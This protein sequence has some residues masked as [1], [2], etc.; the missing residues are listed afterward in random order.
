MGLKEDKEQIKAINAEIEELSKRLRQAPSLF[1]ASDIE[2]AKTYLNGLKQDLREVDSE[3]SYI[4]DSFKRSL[5]ELSKQN[6]ALN[7]GKNSLRAISNISSQLLSI[8][9]G[10]VDADSRSLEKL[11]QKAQLKFQELQQSI[12]LLETENAKT[13]EFS[14][15]LA[16]L[17]GAVAAQSEFLRGQKQVL[18]LQKK[19]EGDRGVKFFD[20]LGD[21]AKAIPGLNK[22]TGA[23]QEAAKAAKDTAR[24]NE[25]TKEYLDDLAEAEGFEGSR[26]E[27]QKE[28][29]KR[30][31]AAKKQREADLEALKTGKGLTEEVQKRLF[32][33]E[34]IAEAKSENE[35]AKIQ[36]E[37]DLSS[38]KSG[39]GLTKETLKR[40]GIEKKFH[41]KD[42]LN[43]LKTGKGLTKEKIKQLG[44]EDKLVSKTGKSL[45]GTSAATKARAGLLA[46]VKPIKNIVPK[47]AVKSLT[48]AAPKAI[49]SAFKMGAKVL[50]KTIS[51]L[52]GPIGL[53]IE[54]VIALF[55]GDK[56][57][58]EL[59][60]SMNMTY[61]DA[62]ATRREFTMIAEESGEIFV[63]TKGIQES[64][65]ALNKSL[66]TNVMLNKDNLVFATMMREQMGFSQE[67]I[68]TTFKLSKA[69]GKSMEQITGE[70][71]AQADITATNLGVQLEEKEILE[72]V[73]KASAATTLSLKGSGRELAKAVTTAKALGMTLQQI[74]NISDN[75][76]NFEQ[77][78][79]NE[80][81]A[82]LLI[83][84]N[85]N[86]ERARL[87]AINN[88]IEGVAREIASQFGSAAE[89]GD[90]NRMQQKAIAEAVGM[91]RDELAE[92]L[93]TQQAIGNATGKEAD[94]RRAVIA[95]M[96]KTMSIEEAQRKLE[97]EG[98][99][100]LKKQASTQERFNAMLDKLTEIAVQIGEP[101]LEIIAPIA[102]L[103]EILLPKIT[104]GL[105]FVVGIIRGLILVIKGIGQGI[106]ALF[107]ND[108]AA[109]SYGDTFSE[110]GS[111]FTRGASRTFDVSLYGKDGFLA[112]AGISVNEAMG[113]DRD[114]SLFTGDNSMFDQLM[115]NTNNNQNSALELDRLRQ[116]NE[117]NYQQQQ[118]DMRELISAVRENRP[119]DDI[120]G[121]IYE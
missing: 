59:A 100:N 86:L 94:E 78:I 13:G 15:Q 60:K 47:G 80:L 71:I 115:G 34:Q 45:A 96:L 99:E 97:K 65:I 7:Q 108:A 51:K 104:G 24:Q 44:L 98:I 110:A 37:A 26:K 28:L 1:K 57:A 42:N 27:F 12:R 76:L 81:K 116:L 22:F 68:N 101:L 54:L 74:E 38:L 58:G 75:I 40:L 83:G 43:A 120:F 21:I 23:F 61:M 95:G 41:T 5:Q 62:L 111:A 107:G 87:F 46:G 66:G 88:N 67:A 14:E 91:T 29:E 103:A 50:T 63:T 8:K 11:Q 79:T 16:E 32:T 4:A 112:D 84:R 39:K 114:A 69:F 36:R 56:A 17:K 119:T 2:Q 73:S 77:S 6:V 10:E 48:K 3:L 52:L 30:D 90:L 89:F 109:A 82:E 20:G 102:D 117:Q 106:G 18:D 31:E 72:E 9:Y 19:I 64:F 49:T 92:T 85:L 33:E 93:F 35:A 121:G 70:V 53:L 113:F 55:Q 118:R 25:L 105:Q